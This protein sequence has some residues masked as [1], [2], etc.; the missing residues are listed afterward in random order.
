M[1]PNLIE[2]GPNSSFVKV[3][4]LLPGQF[5]RIWFLKSCPITSDICSTV[6]SLYH[7]QEPGLLHILLSL[8]PSS[9][10][11][12]TCLG[13]NLGNRRDGIW[14]KD[15]AF[16][17]VQ[18]CFPGKSLAC[19]L[20][21]EPACYKAEGGSGTREMCAAI[22]ENCGRLW[23]L[24]IQ[25]LVGHRSNNGPLSIPCFNYLIRKRI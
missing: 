22:P 25:G 19:H 12:R 16:I 3:S 18:T 8:I 23:D 1:S 20:C 17:S 21:A 9:K 6:W 4:L 24:C 5:Q 2:G 13:P 11:Q 14:T 10:A 7:A 15:C